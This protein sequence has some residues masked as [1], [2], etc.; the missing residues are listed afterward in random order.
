MPPTYPIRIAVAGAGQI[1]KRHLD[2]IAQNA[3][4]K[5]CTVHS[6]VDPSP[7]ARLLASHL[8]V[9]CYEYL[10]QLLAQDLKPDG[11]VLATPN[12][13]HVPQALQCIASGIPI[14]VEKPMA[15]K[16]SDAQQLCDASQRANVAVLVGHHRR[17]SGIMSTSCDVIASG[18]LGKLVAMQGTFLLYKAEN[19]GYF[20]PEWR[21]T[22]GGGPILLN[23][24]HEVGNM[25]ALC[26]EI[27]AVHAFSSSATRGFAVEDT[28]CINIRFVSGA[29]G[30]FIASDA[31]ASTRSWEHT[32]GEDPRYA[33]AH[34]RDDD[35]YVVAGTMG[36]LSIPTMRL[37][38][39][40]HAAEQ[41]WHKALQTHIVS[42]PMVDPMQAQMAHFCDVVR[43]QAAPKVSAFDG[44]QNLKVVEAISE[45]ARTGLLVPID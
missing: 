41:S 12:Q 18:S 22:A 23:M 34:V 8:N 3:V 17:Y 40:A 45:S 9:P 4:Q 44:L 10:D 42:V 28:A 5:N 39:F 27:A 29:L 38:T 25:R 7:D 24:V 19:E 11:I 1:G 14:L 6:I 30:S 20:E 16:V 2:M 35:C 43:Q 36:S 31:A 33:L 32:S 26:G 13:L 21:R 37:K 15:T